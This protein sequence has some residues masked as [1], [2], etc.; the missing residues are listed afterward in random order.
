MMRFW[1][2]FLLS[3]LVTLSAC[4][5]PENEPLGVVLIGEA[6]HLQGAGAGAG[7]GTGTNPALSRAGQLVRGATAEGLVAFSPTG[8]VIPAV[9]ERW[10]VTDDGLSYIFRLRNANWPSGE[11]ITAGDIQARLANRLESLEATALGY[12]LAKITEV[13]EMTGRVIEIRLASPMPDFL[14]LLAQPEMGFLRDGQGAGPM[15]GAKDEN[16]DAIALSPLAPEV[17]GFP[18]RRN[19]DALVRPL[20]VQALPARQAVDAFAE[21]EVDLVLGGDISTFPMADLGPL[22]RANIR[23]DAPQGLFGLVFQSDDG[24]FANPDLRAAMAMAI[25]R[26][27]LIQPFNIG[28]WQASVSIVPRG[29][30]TDIEPQA[31]SWSTLSLEQRR[32]IARERIANFAV[33]SGEEPKVAIGLPQGVGSDMLFEQLA[34]DFALAGLEARQV[35]LGQGADLELHDRVARFNAP[36]WYLNQFHCEIRPGPC[37]ILADG[38]VDESITERDPAKKAELLARAALALQEESIFIGF[39]API[40]WSLVRSDVDAF[41]EN[42]WG[43]HPLFPLSGAP[44]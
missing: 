18:A 25:D 1:P 10:I 20:I 34:S 14:R 44:I 17:R 35:G 26:E 15:L 6:D 16:S 23:L 24:L 22:S 33:E 40:R 41:E 11:D 12:D 29:L 8:D 28:G 19:W 21:G 30:W 27:A 7:A 39:G 32:Q 2:A 13:R 3:S 37:S 38:L 42:V 4:G 9:A 5:G 36:R 31:A 43:V